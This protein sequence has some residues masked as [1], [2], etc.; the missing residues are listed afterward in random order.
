MRK[1]IAVLLLII[2]TMYAVIVLQYIDPGLQIGQVQITIVRKRLEVNFD[3]FVPGRRVGA[4]VE[5]K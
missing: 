1:C 4:W 2:I 5:W 3:N